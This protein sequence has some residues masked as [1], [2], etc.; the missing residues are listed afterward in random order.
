MIRDKVCTKCG[1]T[2]PD[3]EIAHLI[4]EQT[5]HG[6]HVIVLCALHTEHDP[7]DGWNEP[8]EGSDDG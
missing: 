7:R 3:G 5:E 4:R 2:I 8:D 1:R 6:R